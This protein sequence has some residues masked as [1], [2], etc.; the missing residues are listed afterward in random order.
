MINATKNYND[1]LLHDA[2]H[3]TMFWK[4]SYK[5]DD[6]PNIQKTINIIVNN[7]IDDYFC[8]N[9]LWTLAKRL[10]DK[11][12]INLAFEKLEIILNKLLNTNKTITDWEQIRQFWNTYWI[13][14]NEKQEYK[15]WRKMINKIKNTITIN[16]DWHKAFDHTLA[17]SYLRDWDY[18]SA[19]KILT[20]EDNKTPKYPSD[21]HRDTTLTAAQILSI[22]QT[23]RTD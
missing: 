5:L 11:E 7:F 21:S 6:R 3:V 17:V 14:A 2:N 1:D 13:L 16:N 22:K 15:K 20:C 8:I 18:N 4:L 10:N 23:K 19:I 9:T 12:N